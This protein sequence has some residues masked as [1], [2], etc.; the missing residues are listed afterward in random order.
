MKAFPLILSAAAV[1]AC[2]IVV[3]L[4]W[5][6]SPPPSLAGLEAALLSGAALIYGFTAWRP[7]L[8]R[9]L[10]LRPVRGT[11]LVFCGLVAMYVPAELILAAFL[12]GT[13]IRLVWQSACD[14]T[15]KD[16]TEPGVTHAYA[17]LMPVPGRP[18]GAPQACQKHDVQG[19]DRSIHGV[20]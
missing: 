17:D 18:A 14:L 10:W 12:I 19:R 15:E 6:F 11:V 8:P 5:G 3:M 7:T 20:G 13:G 16:G 1:L 9:V 2:G 4:L